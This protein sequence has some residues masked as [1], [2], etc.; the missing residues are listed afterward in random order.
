MKILTRAATI[1]GAMAITGLALGGAACAATAAT[2]PIPEQPHVA[3]VQNSSCSSGYT[4]G[5]TSVDM[6]I[7]NNTTFPLTYEPGLS[8]PSSGHWNQRPAT[9]LDPGQCEVVNA[10][11]PTDLKVFNLN[12]VYSTPWGDYMPFEG[13]ANGTSLSFNPDVFENVPEYHKNNYYWSGAIDPR[14]H[15]TS[16]GESGTL[17]THYQLGLS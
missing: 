5:W 14:Y 16:S 8:G 12:V 10:Y 3:T 6:V 17:H 7:T 11:A 2:P 4:Q 15:I 13:T 1:A 9:T